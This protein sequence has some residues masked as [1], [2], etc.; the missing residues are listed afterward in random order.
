M[1]I[2]RRLRQVMETENVMGTL[3][4]LLHPAL[5]FLYSLKGFKLWK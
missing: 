5:P 2:L 1:L 4:E 3:P